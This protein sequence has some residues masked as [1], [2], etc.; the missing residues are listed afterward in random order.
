MDDQYGNIYI[1]FASPFS[2]QNYIRDINTNGKNKENNII[3][4]LAHEIIYRQVE[5]SCIYIQGHTY[6]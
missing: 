1:N 2:L 6:Y 5:L 3:S 4:T